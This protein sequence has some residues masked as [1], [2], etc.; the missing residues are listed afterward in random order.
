MYWN[1]TCRFGE[2]RMGFFVLDVYGLIIMGLISFVWGVEYMYEKGGDFRKCYWSLIQVL[3]EE[4][5]EC[6]LEFALRTEWV[7]LC[8]RMA[9]IWYGILCLNDFF[10][11]GCCLNRLRVFSCKFEQFFGLIF[12]C[13]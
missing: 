7:I 3:V 4:F 1:Y 6:F 11:I 10:W 12:C 2:N 8:V 5:V 9:G 13:G